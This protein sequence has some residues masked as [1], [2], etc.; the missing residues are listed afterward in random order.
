MAIN[1]S[2]QC[3][4]LYNYLEDSFYYIEGYG[5][6]NFNGRYWK[7][8]SNNI[9]ELEILKWIG[10]NYSSPSEL[11]KFFDMYV[12]THTKQITDLDKYNGRVSFTNGTLYL[13]GKF[14]FVED[15]FY[16]DDMSTKGFD[17]EYNV[18]AEFDTFYKYLREVTQQDSELLLLIQEMMGYCLIDSCKYEK[19]FLLYGEGGTGKSVLLKTISSIWGEENCSNVP[20]DRINEPFMRAGM[21]GKKINFSSELESDIHNTA[22]FK[23]MVSGEEVDAQFKFKDS[24]KFKNTAKM[25]FAMNNLPVIK[26]KTSG[27]FRRLIIIP[28]EK[29]FSETKKCDV[30]LI[31]KILKEKPGIIRFALEGLKRLVSNNGFTKS[32]KSE[33]YVLEYKENNDTIKIFFDETIEFVEE[34]NTKMTVDEIYEKYNIWSKASGFK[35]LNKTNFLKNVT[36][37]Y[38]QVEKKRARIDGQLKY[39]IPFFKFIN[40]E[41]I[42]RVI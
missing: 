38:P 12:M 37:I 42:E 18:D 1:F 24:F 31:D 33:K 40:E 28:F 16:K 6:I 9:L 21:Y 41:I 36:R 5:I 19:A 4:D 15:V 13:F 30:D 17:F 2:D 11:R 10:T 3:K 32:Q 14:Q 34:G 25:L 22:Y 39:I 8:V 23:A 27:T 26:D 7:H 35:P 29:N 20:F